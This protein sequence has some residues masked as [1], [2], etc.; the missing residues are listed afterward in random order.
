M[1]EWRFDMDWGTTLD[2][3]G[4]QAGLETDG[5]CDQLLCKFR[6]ERSEAPEEPSPIME[7]LCPRNKIAESRG[8]TA[9]M[10]FPED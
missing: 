3:S 2:F 7:L 1:G 8:S 9:V 10:Y 4:C 5:R 6:C